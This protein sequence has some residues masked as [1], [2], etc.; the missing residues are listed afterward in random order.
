M[1]RIL[2]ADDSV[3]SRAILAYMVGRAGHLVVAEAKDGTEALARLNEVAPDLVAID[4][5]MKGSDGVTAIGQMRAL[6]PELRIIA[7]TDV[8]Q[9]EERARAAAMGVDGFLQK[10]FALEAVTSILDS[11]LAKAPPSSPYFRHPEGAGHS[12]ER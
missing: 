5:V 12:A 1:S 2:I 7:I 10:P 6:D 9:D 3:V 4:L 8:G 11:L